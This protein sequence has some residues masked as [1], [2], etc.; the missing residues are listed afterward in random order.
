MPSFFVDGLKLRRARIGAK[1]RTN[2]VICYNLIQMS[3]PL[4]T[5]ELLAFT[6]IVSA[7]SLSRAALEL[8]VPRA[9]ISRRLARLEARLGTRLL[10]RTT[11]S[12]ALTDAGT[13]FYRHAQGVLAALSEAEASVRRDEET[14]RGD[15]RV[16]LPPIADEA[17]Y[18]Q[19][20]D[21][22][23][24]YPEV[25]MHV[26]FT[27]RHVD[28]RREGYDVALRGSSELEPGLV[29]R[30][31]LKDRMVGVASP[32]YL[33]QHGTPRTRKDL[34]SHRCLMAFVRGELPQTHWPVAG[35]MVHVEG[36]FFSNE[37][38]L[39]R[40]MAASGLGIA[41]LPRMVV[42]ELLESGELVQVLPGLL[43]AEN[44]VSIV[45]PERE[46]VPAQVRAFASALAAWMP[47]IRGSMRQKPTKR[48]RKRG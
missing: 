32:A 2:A 6:T 7:K 10:R 16:S 9:T 5:A 48:T 26:H 13:L 25:R 36:S 37:I 41:F 3:E 1:A 20:A 21:F 33:A 30:T 35:A 47:Q 22:A 40:H 17:L 43:E 4:E 18:A 45:Y 27:S 12:L 23:R 11:R 28:L 29:A 8:G 34:R 39:L 38:L 19:V 15:L 24:R 14:V 46:F 31:L 44:R 42:D